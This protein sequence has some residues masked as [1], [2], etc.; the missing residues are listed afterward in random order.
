MKTVDDIKRR[1]RKAA[2]ATREPDKPPRLMR[3]AI[4]CA[5]NNPYPISLRVGETYPEDHDYVKRW[6]WA[7]VDAGE[8]SYVDADIRG[9]LELAE[10]LKAQA[11]AD[12]TEGKDKP[13]EAPRW[14]QGIPLENQ[15]ICIKHAGAFGS[16]TP[17]LT[18][19][20]DEP[21]GINA[22]EVAD[23]RWKLVRKNPERFVKVL[24]DGLDVGDA[25]VCL[26]DEHLTQVNAAGEIVRRV[27]R[28]QMVSKGDPLVEIHP[29]MFARAQIGLAP[30]SQELVVIAGKENIVLDSGR[31][32][33]REAADPAP[34]YNPYGF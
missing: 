4:G 34:R 33:G 28:G 30:G 16:S 32:V 11:I 20:G 2:T 7:F 8:A 18:K 12:R 25:L 23:N 6:P 27:Y 3:C 5:T 26:A 10:S 31:L 22:R 21:L 19:A 9:R 29:S 1:V 15:V 24:P 13:R 17:L 14:D